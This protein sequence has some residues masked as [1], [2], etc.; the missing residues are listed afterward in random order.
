MNKL[1][2]PERACVMSLLVSAMAFAA[3][4]QTVTI[5][6]TFDSISGGFPEGVFAQGIDGNLYG[7]TTSGGDYGFGTVFKYSTMA[8]ISEGCNP[9]LNPGILGDPLR[10][11]SLMASSLPLIRS[12]YSAGPYI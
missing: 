3:P 4:A 5:L 11:I 7:T 10:T 2:W 9:S 1:T 12:L 6:A 8:S